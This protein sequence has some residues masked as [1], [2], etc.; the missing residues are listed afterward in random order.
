MTTKVAYGDGLKLLNH[1]EGMNI[2]DPISLEPVKE[3]PTDLYQIPSMIINQHAFNTS[4]I[5]GLFGPVIDDSRNGMNMAMMDFDEFMSEFEYRNMYPMFN[6]MN[7][8]QPKFREDLKKIWNIY[9][10]G[11]DLGEHRYDTRSGGSDA[12]VGDPIEYEIRDEPAASMKK[13]KR[14]GNKTKKRRSKKHTKRKKKQ[15]KK[16]SK[17]KMR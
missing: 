2:I 1:V 7:T 10:G 8:G 11:K 9:S 4:T 14:K 6:F 16:Q 5:K 12:L 17:S 15:K 3:T 13:R